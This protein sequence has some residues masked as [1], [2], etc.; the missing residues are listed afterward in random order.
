MPKTL[1]YFGKENLFDLVS[2]ATKNTLLAIN[3][4]ADSFGKAYKSCKKALVNS[5]HSVEEELPQA[6]KSYSEGDL[7]RFSRD[8]LSLGGAGGECEGHLIR[9]MSHATIIS[10]HPD[11]NQEECDIAVELINH[12]SGLIDQIECFVEEE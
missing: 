7:D 1:T 12:A 8:S 2:H 11:Y 10:M 5:I 9:F 3:G 6:I 4:D